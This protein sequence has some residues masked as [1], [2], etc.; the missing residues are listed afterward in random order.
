MQNM[1]DESCTIEAG[2]VV[3]SDKYMKIGLVVD[4]KVYDN[5][6]SFCWVL[7]NGGVECINSMYLWKVDEKIAREVDEAIRH[8]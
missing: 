8:S 2:D 5:N 3:F 7:I 1:Y 6:Y 4:S